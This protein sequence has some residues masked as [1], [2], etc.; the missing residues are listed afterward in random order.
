MIAEKSNVFY[1]HGLYGSSNSRKFNYIQA[2]H[3]NAICVE[4]KF[5]DNIDFYIENTLSMLANTD[6]HITLIGSS[7]GGNF[8]WQIQQLLKKM[9]RICDLILIN[10]LLDLAY[11]Y[12]DN[13][14]NH[15]VKFIKPMDQFINT[16]VLISSQDEILDTIK[17]QSFF[18]DYD[19]N[20]P[21]QVVIKMVESDHRISNFDE[22]F[23][24]L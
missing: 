18:Q 23:P 8:A 3:P 6:G 4:W 19:K 17:I 1:I 13:F 2:K 5:N 24:D 15:L 7:A 9:D 16:T 20:N 22:V 21:N 11:K 14:P 12:E 10:P